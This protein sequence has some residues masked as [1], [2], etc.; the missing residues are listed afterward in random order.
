[1]CIQRKSFA[2]L[3]TIRH[4]HENWDGSGPEGLEGESIEVGARVVSVANAFAGM[5][6]ARAWRDAMAF[7]QAYSILMSEADAKFDRRAVSALINY[8]ENR[9][10]R[11]AWRHFADRPAAPDA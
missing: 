6:S 9:G 4:I 3:P 2:S 10:G 11:E 7:D 5:T 8:I 1:M